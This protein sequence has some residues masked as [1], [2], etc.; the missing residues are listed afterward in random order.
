MTVK[1]SW[2]PFEWWN[3]NKKIESHFQPFFK[4]YFQP[5]ILLCFTI[6]LLIYAAD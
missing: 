5:T 3:V 4:R 2:L 6:L 1:I